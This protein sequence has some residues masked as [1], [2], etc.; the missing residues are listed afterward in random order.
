MI[1]HAFDEITA[2]F[3]PFR[4]GSSHLYS[5]ALPGVSWNGRVGE[6]PSLVHTCWH[7][8]YPVHLCRVRRPHAA[9]RSASSWLPLSSFTVAVGPT[10][11]TTCTRSPPGS[12][13]RYRDSSSTGSPTWGIRSWTRC[14]ARVRCCWRR[15]RS[16]GTPWASISIRSPFTR[17]RS[18]PRRRTGAWR[19]R[20]PAFWLQPGD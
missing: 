7:P 6:R 13:R 17:P 10:P 8:V 16:A 1:R 12:R 15:G 18:R 14:A 9:T 11:H 19:R 3:G 4:T 2:T 5:A 20:A